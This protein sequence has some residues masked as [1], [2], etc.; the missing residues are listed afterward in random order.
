M[1]KEYFCLF[2][3]NIEMLHNDQRRIED[4]LDLILDG[5]PI[6]NIGGDLETFIVKYLE[7]EMEDKFD[8]I[9]DFIYE[10]E[11][12]KNYKPEMITEKDGSN[13]D[14]ST[15]EKLYDVLFSEMEDV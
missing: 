13:I 12:G 1:T 9:S 2:I 7:K 6:C 8:W 15:A 4:A 5:R 14:L 10:L 11:F 3:Q